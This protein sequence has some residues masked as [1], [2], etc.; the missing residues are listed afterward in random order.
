VMLYISAGR[1]AGMRPADIVGAIA[2]EANLPGKHIG[3]IEIFDDY[4]V[5]GVPAEFQAQVLTAMA[6]ATV[7]GQAANIRLATP[8]DTGPRDR[9][10]RDTA[11]RKPRAAPRPATQPRKKPHR[12]KSK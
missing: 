2:N 5:V 8:R 12:S 4:S 9:A 10:A 11:A 7:R 6:G 1:E 3:P